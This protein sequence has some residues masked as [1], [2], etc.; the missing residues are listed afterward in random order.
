[1]PSLPKKAVGRPRKHPTTED[2][3][4]A[5]RKADHER[6]YRLR[7]QPTAVKG[8]DRDQ[9]RPFSVLQFDPTACTAPIG[10]TKQPTPLIVPN[11]RDHLNLHTILLIIYTQLLLEYTHSFAWVYTQFCLVYTHFYFYTRA[12]SEILK[13]SNLRHT[14]SNRTIICWN[15][16]CMAYEYSVSSTVLVS[17]IVLEYSCHP[18]YSTWSVLCSKA[19]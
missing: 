3:R 9:N 12:H 19:I 11:N 6:V 2:A 4:L 10:P 1:M 17:S 15:Y 16:S 7:H 13:S 8:E 14:Y 18:S 5:K